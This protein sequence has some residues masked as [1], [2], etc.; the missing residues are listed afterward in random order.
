[1]ALKNWSNGDVLYGADMDDFTR[2]SIMRFPTAASRT[3]TLVGGLAPTPGMLAY[4]QDTNLTNRYVDVGGTQYWA[5][6]SGMILVQTGG[7]TTGDGGAVQSIPNATITP[8]TSLA[9]TNFRNVNNW[10][11]AATGRF[12][13]SLPGYYEFT[14]SGAISNDATNYNGVRCLGLRLN[15]AASML[16]GAGIYTG[17]GASHSASFIDVMMRP[18]VQ[19]LNGTGDYIDVCAYQTSSVALNFQASS[20]DPA[21]FSIRYM[22]R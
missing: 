7:V 3:S 1:M 17:T 6:H 19:Y 21:F 18:C 14:V 8:L 13:P 16:P 10:F 11:T 12:L 15:G 22:G 2:N 9:V 5:L 20:N 4:A